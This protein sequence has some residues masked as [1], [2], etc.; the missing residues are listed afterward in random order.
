[1]MAAACIP[2]RYLLV[3]G[4]LPSQGMF[5]VSTG[6]QPPLRAT[7]VG[8]RPDRRDLVRGSTTPD[9]GTLAGLL[10]TAGIRISAAAERRRARAPAG[11]A[12][13]DPSRH[14]TALRIARSIGPTRPQR[15]VP[16]R[17]RQA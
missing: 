1:M 7:R 14:R 2:W 12:A 4:T 5:R 3:S 15:R 6:I 13:R 11:S 8:A 10:W 16:A 17:L 9:A